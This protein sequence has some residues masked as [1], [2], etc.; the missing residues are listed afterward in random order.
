[1]PEIDAKLSHA[2][3][4][5][6][7]DASPNLVQLSVNYVSNNLNTDS[8]LSWNPFCSFMLGFSA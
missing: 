1:M 4:A 3:E 7:G 6:C 2:T 5:S 8:I